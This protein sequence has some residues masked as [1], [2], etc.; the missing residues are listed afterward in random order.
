MESVVN[1]REAAEIYRKKGWAAIPLENDANG[2]PKKPF[3]PNWQVQSP[4]A[5][6]QPPETWERATGLGLVLGRVSNGL[7]AIDIDDVELAKIAFQVCSWTRVVETIRHRAH[8]YFIEQTPSVSRRLTISYQGRDVCVELKSTGTQVAAPPTPG[9][10]RRSGLTVKPAVTPTVAAAW[11][12]VAKLLGVNQE[13]PPASPAGV[14]AWSPF[15]PK[16]HRNNTLYV[17]AHRLREAGL[18]LELALDHLRHR[19]ETRYESGELTWE[20]CEK[21]IKS[22]YR[23]LT[24]ERVDGRNTYQLWFGRDT[25]NDGGTGESGSDNSAEHP[26]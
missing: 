11:G 13:M 12:Q 21:T 22:A 16:D 4:Y 3:T 24:P 26:P 15:V 10:T 14:P 17:E 7:C 18:S 20:E 25:P 9:Y 19:F 5:P 6:P 2:Y 1:L 23:K 8:L